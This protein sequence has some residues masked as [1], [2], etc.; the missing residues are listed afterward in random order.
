MSRVYMYVPAGYGDV[1]AGRRVGARRRQ[2]GV[3]DGG[4]FRNRRGQLPD[5]NVIVVVVAVVIRVTLGREHLDLGAA[6]CPGLQDASRVS[7]ER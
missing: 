4:A 1:G 6:R 7:H 2:L 3:F 5:G